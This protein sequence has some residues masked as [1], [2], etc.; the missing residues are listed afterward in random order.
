[1]NTPNLYVYIIVYLP[2]IGWPQ[3]WILRLT[4]LWTNQRYSWL[5]VIIIEPFLYLSIFIL[6]IYLYQSRYIS[7]NR[8]L[9]IYTY[10]SPLCYPFSVSL[11]YLPILSIYRSISKSIHLSIISIYLPL[12]TP[13]SLS[14]LTSS[15]CTRRSKWAG[16]H[17]TDTI[18]GIGSVHCTLQTIPFT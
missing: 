17:S 15:T 13:A 10:I 5:G 7:V 4:L 9:S 6:Y 14:S 3:R 1:M 16:D 2:V 11:F 8:Y 18:P 12:L